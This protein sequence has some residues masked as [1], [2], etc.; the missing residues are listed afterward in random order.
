M[1]YHN[2][3][4]GRKH[5][6]SRKE[7][8]MEEP[9]LLDYLKAKLTPWRK[10]KIEIPLEEVPEEAP[11]KTGAGVHASQEGFSL[12][13]ELSIQGAV[14]S[15]GVARA[16]PTSPD[17]LQGDFLKKV[18]FPWRSLLA[19][20]LALIAQL[21]MQPS[22]G[23]SWKLGVVLYL[24][25][26]AFLAWAYFRSEWAVDGSPQAG[27]DEQFSSVSP[28]SWFVIRRPFFLVFSFALGVISFLAFGGNNFNTLNVSLWTLGLA[29]LVWA[30]WQPGEASSSLFKQIRS[31]FLTKE[32]QIRISRQ[33]L[34]LLAAVLLVVFFRIYRIQQV[35]PEMFS[36]HAEKLLDI[37]DVLH[38]QTSIFFM[39]NTGREAFQMYLT[40]AIIKIFGTGYSFLSLKL[41]TVLAGL[42]TLPYIYLLGRDFE[43]PRV[44][45]YAMLFAGIAYWP[46]LISRVGLRFPLYP[47][48]VA[49]T[50]YYL[51]RGLRNSKPNDF[52]LAGLAL[53]IG[54][55]GYTPIRIL[56][57]VV[58]IT[59][60]LYL[61]HRQPTGYKAG[62]VR[63]LVLLAISAFFVFLPL[64]RFSLENPGGVTY[65][66]LTRLGTIEQPL[67]GPAGQIFLGNLWKALSMFAWDNGE[68]WAI[69]VTHRPALDVVSAVLFY[70][71]SV[72]VLLRYL[73]RRQWPDLFWLLAVP[74][75]M[76]PSILSLAF[77]AENP[78]L[79]RLS[80]AIVPVF[81]IV[82]LALDGFLETLKSQFGGRLG[83]ALAVG[84]GLFLVIW[85]SFQNFDI[86]FNQYQETYLRS[87][88]NTSELGQVI[89]DFAGG[90]G[91]PDTAWVIAYPHW[92]DTRLVAMNAGFPTRDYGIWPENLQETLPETRAKLF[93]LKPEDEV[94][95]STLRQ[96]YPD[97]IQSVYPSKVEGHDFLIYFVPPLK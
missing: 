74:L 92:V 23:R 6:R 95:L 73:R 87:S 34:L 80:G 83:N 51:L 44:G 76:L 66:T 45:L 24:L 33:G 25:G 43:N 35:P 56:P 57:F 8:V 82:G 27:E 39:R 93:L 19:F 52:L 97:G 60:G 14:P 48:F 86:A 29:A 22:P 9:T 81:L 30:V 37:W 46:N 40:A 65:R 70:L 11:E 28:S 67:P 64:L 7:I 21:T 42:L 20:A 69:S 85:A 12:G 90:S 3:S 1:E 68:I 18:V 96:L 47:L 89:H 58:L 10:Q 71:G 26:M 62:A 17:A 5:D 55:H 79:N 77:P 88:W 72:F 32:W 78:A 84:A 38:G 49:P 4:N 31:I 61:L 15:P 50:L 91:T 94:G 16:L 2:S 63:G 36:D 54:L 41:G 13:E 59:V 75:L 53:G